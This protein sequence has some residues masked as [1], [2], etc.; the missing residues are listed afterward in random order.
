M[1]EADLCNCNGGSDIVRSTCCN[2]IRLKD[3]P[4]TMLSQKYFVIYISDHLILTL[5]YCLLCRGCGGMSMY[6]RYGAL[7]VEGPYYIFCMYMT[8]RTRPVQP[9]SLKSI[10]PDGDGSFISAQSSQIT[11]HVSHPHVKG[12]LSLF[13]FHFTSF[14]IRMLYACRMKK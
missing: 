4:P 12:L 11:S 8:R 9:C 13:L 14:F 10:S 6:R 3:A 1:R 2:Y 7:H 5:S